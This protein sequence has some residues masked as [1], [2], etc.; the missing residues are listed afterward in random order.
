[1]IILLVSI[2]IKIKEHITLMSELHSCNRKRKAEKW[3]QRR[4]FYCV[5]AYP[6][7][8]WVEEHVQTDNHINANYWSSIKNNDKGWNQNL[9]TF[10]LWAMKYKINLVHLSQSLFYLC[11]SLTD[12]TGFQCFG[13]QGFHIR[14]FMEKESVKPCEAKLL[15]EKL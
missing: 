8:L 1:M 5:K 7:L 11:L 12:S 4:V 3:S 2:S 6:N 13:S 9:E 10:L 14:L 15:V